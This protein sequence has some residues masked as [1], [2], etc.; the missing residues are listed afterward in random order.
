MR[1]FGDISVNLRGTSDNFERGNGREF[2]EIRQQGIKPKL[3]PPYKLLLISIISIN[4]ITI[5][6]FKNFEIQLKRL[7]KKV[8]KFHSVLGTFLN[9]TPF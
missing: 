6:A 1:E 8:V 3:N 2:S 9:P 7:I 5:A 4:N